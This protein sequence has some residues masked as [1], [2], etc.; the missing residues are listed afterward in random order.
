L[1]F[2]RKNATRDSK[3]AAK[4]AIACTR[5][6]FNLATKKGKVK[7]NPVDDIEHLGITGKRGRVLSLQEIWTFWNG[8]E[9]AGVPPVTANAL[10][11]ALVTMQRSKEI[12]HMQYVS[13]R[14]D[15][16]VWHMERHETKNKTMHRVPLNRHALEIIEKVRPFTGASP[17]VFGATRAFTA[18]KEK[19]P[20]LGAVFLRLRK[21]PRRAGVGVC[22]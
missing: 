2:S 12:R 4:H 14:P 7:T 1:T 20:D 3:V 10:K 18:P 8:L 15:E 21:T 6:L 16:G 17:Y 11:F 22:A 5:R 9:A 19:N 13:I